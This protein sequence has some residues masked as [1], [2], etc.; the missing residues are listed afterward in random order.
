ML[1]PSGGVI[2]L[3]TAMT[4]L[5]ACRDEHCRWSCA[6]PPRPR[7]RAWAADRRNRRPG[8]GGAG[9]PAYRTGADPRRAVKGHWSIAWHRSPPAAGSCPCA[10]RPHHCCRCPPARGGI[11]RQRW[12]HVGFTAAAPARPRA[13]PGAR[14]RRSAVPGRETRAGVGCGAGLDRARAGRARAPGERSQD[15][16]DRVAGPSTAQAARRF[17]LERDGHGLARAPPSR[18]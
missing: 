7:T 5:E 3:S 17:H 15:A 18:S 6:T 2:E 14:L 11:R 13:Q 9:Q 4:A 12:R 1:R 8:H 16:S 10:A